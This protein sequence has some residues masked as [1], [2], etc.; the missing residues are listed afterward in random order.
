MTTASFCVVL[1]LKHGYIPS[2]LN[3]NW[4]CV[5]ILGSLFTF[6]KIIHEDVKGQ[7]LTAEESEG[8]GQIMAAARA[9]PSPEHQASVMC[10]ATGMAG[11][12]K[13]IYS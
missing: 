4:I 3:C 9:I 12:L 1:K 7:Q 5:A 13:F 11:V 6:P 10:N 8:A 2:F